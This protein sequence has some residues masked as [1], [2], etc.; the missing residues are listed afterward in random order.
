MKALIDDYEAFCNESGLIDNADSKIRVVLTG[1]TIE[2]N[3]QYN[4]YYNPSERGYQNSKYI[5][6]YKNKAVRAIGEV[7]CIADVKYQPESDNLEVIALMQGSLTEERIETIKKATT[8]AKENY[9]YSV[10]EGRRFFFVEKYYETVYLKPTKGALMGTRYID[11]EEVEGYK[12]EMSAAQ[13]AKLL[14]GKE[15]DI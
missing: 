3:L 15:W 4:I 11:L 2:Q 10:D 6:L 5:G 13:V 14:N 8:E 7:A 9:G 12:K 1:Q